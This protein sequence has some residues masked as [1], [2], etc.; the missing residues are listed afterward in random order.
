MNRDSEAFVA[1]LTGAQ[2]SLYA[3]ILALLPDRAAARDILQE[4]NLTLWNKAADFEEGTHFMAWAS[5]IAR[6]HILNHRKK[7]RRDRLVFDDSLFELL[8]ERQAARVEEFDRR[9]EA[10]RGCLRKLPAAQREL[11]E[12]RYADDGSVQ[13]IAAAAGKS[14]GAVSQTLYRIRENLLNCIHASLPAEP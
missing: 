14:V 12:R 13:A 2:N 11:V 9:E 7:K 6:Y 3:C 10:L 8:C 5:R 4:T 1:L